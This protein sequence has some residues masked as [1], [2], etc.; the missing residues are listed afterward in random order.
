MSAKPKT[1]DECLADVSPEKRAALETLRKTIQAA[2][3]AA[4]EC[5]SYGLADTSP[6]TSLLRL[7]GDQWDRAVVPTPGICE[8]R[9]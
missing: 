7:A 6:G 4:E 3:P 9:P 8:L 2:A 5:V 1:I